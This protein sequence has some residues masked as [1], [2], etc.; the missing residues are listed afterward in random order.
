MGR[1]WGGLYTLLEPDRVMWYQTGR[2]VP[3]SEVATDDQGTTGEKPE[4]RRRRCEGM[5]HIRK[6]SSRIGMGPDRAE[7]PNRTGPYPNRYIVQW[8]NSI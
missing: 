4:K 8:E 1:G 5:G 7:L 3:R 2:V 6:L